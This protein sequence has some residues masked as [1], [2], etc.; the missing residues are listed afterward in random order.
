MNNLSNEQKKYL[1]E[2]YNKIK[3]DK[4]LNYVN[5]LVRLFNLR[6]PDPPHTYN[7]LYNVIKELKVLI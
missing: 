5:D 7:S 3:F 6:Y 4:K 1:I 2:I